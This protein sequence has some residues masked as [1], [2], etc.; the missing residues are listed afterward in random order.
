MIGLV[1][2]AIA[3]AGCYKHVVREEGGFGRTRQTIY[4][5]N[6]KD[7]RIPVVDDAEDAIFGKRKPPAK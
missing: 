7:D 2:T 6:L 1:A 4:E 5:P 3:V